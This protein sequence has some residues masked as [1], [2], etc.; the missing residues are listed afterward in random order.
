MGLWRIVTLALVALAPAALNAAPPREEPAEAE[1]LLNLDL[2]MESDLARDRDLLRWLPLL[3]QLQL[4]E[5]LKVL[6]SEVPIPSV[7]TEEN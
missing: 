3:E 1:L 7:R 6:D 4:L 5:E 2:L